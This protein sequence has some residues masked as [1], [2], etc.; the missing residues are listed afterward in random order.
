LE[1]L[2]GQT[3]KDRWGYPRPE[4]AAARTYTILGDIDKALPMLARAIPQPTQWC[5]TPAILRLGPQWDPLRGDPRF[6]KIV[7]SFAPQETNK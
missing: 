2:I 3:Q 5:L 6:E 1:I 4:E 7:S